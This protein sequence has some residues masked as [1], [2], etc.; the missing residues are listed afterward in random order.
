MRTNK[1]TIFKCLA[2]A[3]AVMVM[4]SAAVGLAACNGTSSSDRLVVYTNSGSGGRDTWWEAEAKKAGFNVKVID[5]GADAMKE[6]IVSEQRNPQGDVMCGLNA[7]GWEDLKN[8]Q[9]IEKYVPSWANDVAEGMNDPDG[10]YHAI[11]QESILLIYDKEVWTAETAPK[12]WTDIWNP[13]NTQYHGQF[14]CWSALT[15]GTT[16]CVLTGIMA[17]YRDDENGKYGVSS[18]GWQQIRNMYTY[19]V[20]AQGNVFDAMSNKNPSHTNYKVSMGQWYS[21]GLK[22]YSETYYN[23]SKDQHLLQGVGYVVPEAGVP[24]TITGCGIIKGTK[25]LEL[26]KKFLDWYGGEEFQTLWAQTWDTAPCNLKALE[27][28]SEDAKAFASLPE[29]KI[30][31][32][33]AQSHMG[34][35]IQEITLQYMK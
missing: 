15:G 4:G 3:S 20:R 1:K 19:G 14:Q 17:R 9:L 13:A 33:W 21:S 30:D 25:K 12:D 6:K 31:W 35:W 29:Q 16:Q 5:G 24:H 10:Y 26:A 27:N 22:N 32:K 11:A 2:V 8:Q 28:A 34:E 23:K 7:M 18:E